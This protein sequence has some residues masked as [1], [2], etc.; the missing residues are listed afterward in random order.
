MKQRGKIRSALLSLSLF[1]LFVGTGSLPSPAMA[2]TGLVAYYPFN[3]N[4][5]DE[6]GN[7]NHGDPTGGPTL[8][9]DILGISNAA[10]NFPGG[11]GITVPLSSSILGSTFQNGYTIAAWIKPT[12]LPNSGTDQ[13]NI[14]SKEN[15]NIFLRISYYPA[16]DNS[17]INAYHRSEGVT[18]HSA[19]NYLYPL[20]AG[21]WYHVAVTWDKATGAWEIY[22]NGH[23]RGNLPAIPALDTTFTGDGGFWIGKNQQYG[24]FFQGTIDEVYVYSRALSETEIQQLLYPPVITGQISLT[25]NE[26][27]ILEITLAD[28][29]VIDPD[30]TY[31]TGFTLTVQDGSNYT[32]AGN[33]IT[34][35]P[36]FYGNLAVP[37]TVNDGTLDSAVFNLTVFVAPVDDAPV[38]TGQSLLSTAEDTPL[39]ITLADL[40]VDDLDNTYPTGFTLTVWDGSNYI[41]TENIIR[42]M[43]NFYGNLAVPVTVNDGTLDSAVFNLIVA[44][45][46]VVNDSDGDLIPDFNDNCPTVANTDQDDFDE[47]GIGN[48]CDNC[49]FIENPEQSN[50]DDDAYGDACDLCPTETNDGGPCSADTGEGSVGTGTNWP[51]VTVTITYKAASSGVTDYWIPPDCENVIWNTDPPVPQNCRRKAPYILAVEEEGAPGL[52]IPSGDWVPVQQGDSKTITCDLTNVFDA[53]SLAAAGPVMI[54][55]MYTSFSTD[56]GRDPATGLCKEGD[57]CVDETKY[58]LIQ[59]TIIAKD[60][61]TKLAAKIDIRPASETNRIFPRLSAVFKVIPVAVL[62]DESFNAVTKVKRDSLYF[63]VIGNE[64]SLLRV[65]G[66]PACVGFDVDGDKDRDL[67]CL[68]I[69]Q[70]IGTISPETENLFMTGGIKS[71]SV[72]GFTASD[73]VKVVTHGCK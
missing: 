51:F 3:G 46:E 13:R 33:I 12:N 35:M 34:P 57:I 1:I 72:T 32:R 71:D 26:D 69:T 73:S 5:H 44:V 70:K 64:D 63:G 6:S 20:T 41:R 54:T 22:V 29:T 56:R 23:P 47:D 52:G 61:V 17:F 59:G 21:T 24:H 49:P 66:V 2:Q 36:N 14:F 30:N 50:S 53:A 8:T 40:T 67:V 25:V 31:P 38:I 55:P 39:E 16:A 11:G 15:S 9:T 4:A 27:G 58:N 28:L 60:V 65:G 48:A 7:D 18:S 45:T 10:Y 42:P 19:A 37:V 62:S 68:F 43:P